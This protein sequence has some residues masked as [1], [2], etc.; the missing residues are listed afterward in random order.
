MCSEPD[1]KHH[2]RLVIGGERLEFSTDGPGLMA[3]THPSFGDPRGSDGP[4]DMRLHAR[5]GEPQVPA[6]V[7]PCFDAGTWRLYRLPGRWLF[8]FHSPVL[9]PGPYKCVTVDQDY[10]EG[11]VLVRPEPFEGQSAVD[12]FDYPLDELLVIHRLLHHQRGIELHAC[13]VRDSAGAGYL[14]V[15]ASGA[16]KT[17]MAQLWAQLPGVQILSDDR[18][19]VRHNGDELW[20]HGTPWHGEGCFAHGAS[21]PLGRIFFLRHGSDNETIPVD[22]VP[23]TMLLFSAT[24]AVFH[25]SLLAERA[26]ALCERLARAV[27]CSTLGFSPTAAAVD[28]VRQVAQTDHR[29]QPR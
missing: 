21:A 28:Y 18:V 15:G 27:P 25:D 12:P 1:P 8:C 10:R 23:T 3:R 2:C 19:I 4:P 26:L 9:G 6:D 17:T 11:E 29:V 5:W 20:L 13:A 16:G 22:I 14:F 7:A 24:F